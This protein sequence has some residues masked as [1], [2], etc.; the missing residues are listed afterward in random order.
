MQDILKQYFDRTVWKYIK[1]GIG[2]EWQVVQYDFHILM[3]KKKMQK[4]K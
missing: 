2:S 3:Q 1:C 4:F